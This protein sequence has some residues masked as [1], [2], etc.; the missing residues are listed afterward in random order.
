[1]LTPPLES[2][3]AL[4]M[5]PAD[6]DAIHAARESLIRAVA[7]A[8]ARAFGN[9]YRVLGD[10]RAFSPDAASAGRRALRNAC[11]R[12]LTARDDEDAAK[13]A[14]AH[15]PRRD[16]HDRHDGGPRAAHAA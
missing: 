16:K 15:Y 2:E 12:Y 13:L 14:D 3:L 7:E 11:L 6:P 1:M 4:A 10:A 5:Q 9:L 8:H